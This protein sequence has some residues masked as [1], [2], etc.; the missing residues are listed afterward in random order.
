MQRS[1]S[2]S[3]VCPRGGVQEERKGPGQGDLYLLPPEPQQETF[4]GGRP[5][6]GGGRG[7]GEEDSI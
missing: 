5:L 2:A 6:L 3:L 1:P 7:V 4:P